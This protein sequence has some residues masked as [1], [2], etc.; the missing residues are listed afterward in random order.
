MKRKIAAIIC[1]LAMTGS[2]LAG[3]GGNST[4]ESQSTDEAKETETAGEKTYKDT[5]VYSLD[6]TPTGNFV[7]VLSESDYNTSVMDVVHASLLIPDAEGNLEDYLAESHEVSEDGT[8]ITFHLHDNAYFSDGEKVTADDVAF[9]F[10]YM[11]DPTDER[12]T[13]QTTMIKGADE[14]RE[15]KA[16]SIEGIKVID[17][18]TI[19]FTLTQYFPKALSFIG[20]TGIAPEHIWKDVPYTEIE[21]TRELLGENTVGCGPYHVSELVEDQYVKLEANDNFFLGDVATKYFIF[22]VTN[23]DSITTELKTGNV[24]IAAVTNLLQAELDQIDNDGFDIKYFPYDLVQAIVFS[25]SDEGGT[26]EAVKQAIRYGMDVK[27]FI[28]NYMEGRADP[29]PILISSGS[30]AFP[31]DV[32]YPDAD[33][34]AAKRALEDGGYKDVND[35]GFVE[36]PDGNPYTFRLVY[37]TGLTCREQFAVVLQEEAKEFGLNIELTGTDFPSLMKIMKDPSAYEAYLMGNGVDSVDP[38]LYAFGYID[39]FAESQEAYD[40]IA[41]ASEE[42]DQDKRCDLYKEAAE[43]LVTA[44]TTRMSLFCQ[45]KAYAYR[46]TIENYGA[47]SFNN[48][49]HIHEW[50]MAE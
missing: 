49:Y 10:T 7:P 47:G 43:Y 3:C 42:L 27:G 50:K 36:D 31:D 20:E 9:T 1:M 12:W 33:I 19:E 30:W 16:D 45:E 17:D 48:F 14:Y 15:G 35:D 28:E 38:D 8:V 40:L 26:P 39:S 32:E 24:D 29:A 2:M 23:A 44:P 37:P 34:D 13:G 21:N 46:D 25:A 41:E 11:S 6:A 18:N 4:D 5:I 22:R